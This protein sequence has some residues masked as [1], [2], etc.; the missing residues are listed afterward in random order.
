MAVTSEVGFGSDV[1]NDEG[2]VGG[3]GWEYDTTLRT[4]P[5]WRPKTPP[6]D[7][8]GNARD[9]PD[10]DMIC[11][12]RFRQGSSLLLSVFELRF[13]NEAEAANESEVRRSLGIYASTVPPGLTAHPIS[14]H[15][16]PT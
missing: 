12:T 16:I 1:A 10:A 9:R 8:M 13:P 3:P 14:S 2:G 15:L 7:E 11:G 5:N 4:S 6:T